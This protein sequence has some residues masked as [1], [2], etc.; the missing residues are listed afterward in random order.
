MEAEKK[1]PQGSGTITVKADVKADGKFMPS[2]SGTAV[3]F[4]NCK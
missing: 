4:G 1:I 3:A 2:G